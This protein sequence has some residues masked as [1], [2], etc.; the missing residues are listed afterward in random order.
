MAAQQ[1]VDEYKMHSALRRK[2][3]PDNAIIVHKAY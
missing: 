2:G 1:N 3:F